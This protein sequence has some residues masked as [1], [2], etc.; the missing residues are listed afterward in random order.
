MS[1]PVYV[2]VSESQDIHLLYYALVCHYRGIGICR[3]MPPFSHILLCQ[4]HSILYAWI[5]VTTVVDLVW[6]Q[7]SKPRGSD[8]DMHMR[9]T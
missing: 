9:A 6:K 8:T 3:T 5:S 2:H 7:N 1:K 4:C